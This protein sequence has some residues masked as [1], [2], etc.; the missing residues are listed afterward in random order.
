MWTVQSLVAT[1]MTSQCYVIFMQHYKYVFKK[2]VWNKNLPPGKHKWI[3]TVRQLYNET[4]VI[5]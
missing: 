1:Y 3:H 4:E 5:E 2:H